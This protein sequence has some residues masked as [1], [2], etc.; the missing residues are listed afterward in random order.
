MDPIGDVNS[1]ITQFEAKYGLVHPVF[2]RGTYSQALDEAKKELQF[3]LVYLHS[4]LHQDTD[5]FCTDILG[6]NEVVSY[7][8]N[9]RIIFWGCSIRKPEGYRVSLALRENSYPFLA[10]IAL[11]ENRMT[12]ARRY[13]GPTTVERFIR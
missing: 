4:D 11:K 3:L 2:Y 6:H 12:V 1:F 8:S 7:L 13:E 5:E 10:L 9:N